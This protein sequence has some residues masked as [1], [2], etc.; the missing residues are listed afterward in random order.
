MSTEA[1][2]ATEVVALARSLVGTPWAEYGAD[3]ADGFDCIGFIIYVAKQVGR[4]PSEW[5]PPQYDLRA[6]YDGPE[7][8][9]ETLAALG[10]TPKDSE[11][12]APGDILCY[13]MPVT[14]WH[15]GIYLGQDQ[16]AHAMPRYGV[17]VSYT[18][19]STWRRRYAGA[20]DPH[21]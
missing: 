8:L 10:C 12:P 5:T 7:L 6:G 11:D 20:W 9:L 1:S 13:R 17:R 16:W 18:T 14:C 15:A 3:P 19:E 2:R 4:L 21:W